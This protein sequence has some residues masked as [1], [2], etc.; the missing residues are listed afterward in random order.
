[1]LSDFDLAKHSGV[2][3]GRPA[4]I[5]QSELNGV[6]IDTFIHY[7]LRI[8]IFFFAYQLPLVDTKSCTANFRTNSFVGT[9]G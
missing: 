1:M 7:G 3:G 2:I 9:E 6:I 4:T 8:L 5:H